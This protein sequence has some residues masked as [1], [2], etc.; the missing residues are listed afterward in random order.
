MSDDSKQTVTIDEVEY[1]IDDLSDEAKTQL[2]NLK[3]VDDKILQLNNEWAISDTAR[4]GY[5]QALQKE[6]AKL[7]ENSSI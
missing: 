7:N 4:I 5:T 2:L 6:L 1:N 3:F